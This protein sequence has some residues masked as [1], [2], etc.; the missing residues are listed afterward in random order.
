MQVMHIAIIII[1]IVCF[2]A[3]VG[4]VSMWR[5]CKKDA[6]RTEAEEIAHNAAMDQLLMDILRRSEYQWR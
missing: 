4:L 2:C 6:R 5:G 1:A 3:G